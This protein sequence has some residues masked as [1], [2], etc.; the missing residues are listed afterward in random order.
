M[1]CQKKSMINSRNYY[2]SLLWQCKL[3]KGY[4][5]QL[6]KNDEKEREKNYVQVCTNCCACIMLRRAN[7]LTV[8]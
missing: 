1:T 5:C 8:C 4:H 7:H 2:I 3:L 6:F